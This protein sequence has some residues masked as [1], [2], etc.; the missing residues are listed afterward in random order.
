VRNLRRCPE[1]AKIPPAAQI[2]L[3]IY[4]R[5][6]AERRS[7]KGFPPGLANSEGGPAE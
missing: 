1:W 6:S 4:R 2:S 3:S 7:T 5:C